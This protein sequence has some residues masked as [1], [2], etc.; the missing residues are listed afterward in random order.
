MENSNRTVISRRSRPAK[1]PLS[2]DI[3]VKTA[4]ELLKNEGSSGLSMRKVAKALDTGPSSLYVYVKSLQELSA[5]VYDYGLGAVVFPDGK[6]GTW[7]SNLFD[8][9]RSYL[10]VLFE[11]PGIA[12]LSLTTIPVGPNS[13]AITEYILGRMHEGGIRS[14]SAAWGVDLL[15]LYASS[16]A[17]EQSS[18]NHKGNTLEALSAS[19]QTVDVLK[20]PMIGSLKEVLLSSGGEERF[21][22]GLEVILQGIMFRQE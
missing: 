3:I 7:K 18:R 15:L 4:L 22:W 12:E 21:R 17:F 13:L 16:V 19:Y 14:T 6:D 9:L 8:L 10:T 20:Y 11:S 1:E 2:K 5:F